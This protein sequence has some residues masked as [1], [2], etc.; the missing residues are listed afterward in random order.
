MQNKIKQNQM[1]TLLIFSLPFLLGIQGK[2]CNDSRN[3]VRRKNTD[4]CKRYVSLDDQS[5]CRKHCE[6]HKD[7]KDKLKGEKDTLI[8]ACRFGQELFLAMP[9]PDAALAFNRCNNLLAEHK[10]SLR[11]CFTGISDEEDRLAKGQG[12][13][14]EAKDRET[15][16]NKSH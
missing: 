6:D 15:G 16:N 8:E 5:E 2:S 10:N 9:R 12:L 11:A 1:V 3:E 7:F 14:S 4:Y 13:D